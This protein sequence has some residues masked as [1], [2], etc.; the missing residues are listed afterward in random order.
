VPR[1]LFTGSCYALSERAG[2]NCSWR[3][4]GPLIVL[5]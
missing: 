4:Y 3:S 2:E 1:I 5:F